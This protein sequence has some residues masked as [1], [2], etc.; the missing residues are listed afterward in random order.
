MCKDNNLQL[1]DTNEEP[2]IPAD[3]KAVSKS[4]KTTEH[5]KK[6]LH[7]CAEHNQLTETFTINH[8]LPKLS[9]NK[10]AV[11]SCLSPVNKIGLPYCLTRILSL[12]LSVMELFS[13]SMLLTSKKE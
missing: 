6:T 1:L 2:N 8:L 12:F 11:P 4:D 7:N 10:V 3:S 9:S 5:V 13:N